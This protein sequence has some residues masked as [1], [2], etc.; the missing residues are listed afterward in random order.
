[1]R[2]AAEQDGSSATGEAHP[3]STSQLPVLVSTSASKKSMMASGMSIL[4]HSNLD[5]C[6]KNT[7]ESRT[8]L[9][10]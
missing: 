1:M 9:V 5:A 2:R 7:C 10:N 4:G 8:H 6:S 3:G